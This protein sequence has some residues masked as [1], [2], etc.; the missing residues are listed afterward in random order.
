MSIASRI[1]WSKRPRLRVSEKPVEPQSVSRFLDA[2]RQAEHKSRNLR[3]SVMLVAAMAGLLALCGYLVFGLWGAAI[4]LVVAAGLAVFAPKVPPAAVIRMYR[5]QP[6][7]PRNS[8]RL[9]EIVAVLSERAGLAQVPETYIIPSA[10]LNA[11]ATGTRDHAAIAIT[12]GLLRRLDLRELTGVVAHEISHIENN[13]LRTMALADAL[14]RVTQTL[15]FAGIVMVVTTLPLALFGQASVPW[16]AALVLYLAPTLG[17]LMQLGLSRAREYDADLEAAMLTGDPAGLAQ[18]L[19][20]VD[21]RRGAFW[22]DLIYMGRRTPQ[23]SLLRT[24]PPTE[25]RVRRLL[26]LRLRP[27]FPPLMWPEREP[28]ITLV[29]FGPIKLKPRYHFPG[30][31]F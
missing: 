25:E 24:H 1:E 7:T 13:D 9:L 20:K 27:E 22:E 14:S 29:G 6:A 10:T 16:L 8:G 26:D 28:Q 12:E 21:Q 11:F 30:V 17:S 3:H 19:E 18:A 4:A 15:S 23:P 2:E 5:G 31:W